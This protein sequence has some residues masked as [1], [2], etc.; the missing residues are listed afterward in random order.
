MTVTEGI[1]TDHHWLGRRTVLPKIVTDLGIPTIGADGGSDA[2]P[3]CEEI[4]PNLYAI[5]AERALAGVFEL[6]GGH[7]T[8]V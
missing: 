5:K 7:D 6:R 2:A 1:R 8:D 4:E 3:V